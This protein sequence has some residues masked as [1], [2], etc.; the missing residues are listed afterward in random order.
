MSDRLVAAGE[1]AELAIVGRD[2]P[3]HFEDEQR[4]GEQRRREQREQG[5]VR[6]HP[7]SVLLPSTPTVTQGPAVTL[8]VPPALPRRRSCGS[9]QWTARRPDQD[10]YWHKSPASGWFKADLPHPWSDAVDIYVGVV[11]P[12]RQLSQ[13][14]WRN[15]DTEEWGQAR[16]LELNWQ[17]SSV[18]GFSRLVPTSEQPVHPSLADEK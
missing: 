6:G 1:L 12:T 9:A 2:R 13:V 5:S 3:R 8:P 4:Q 16:V 11:K 15:V 7:A 17:A 10:G 14:V 18:P